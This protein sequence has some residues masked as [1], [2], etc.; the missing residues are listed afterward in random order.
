MAP[1]HSPNFSLRQIRYF[2]AVA[3][4][5]QV[6]RAAAVLHVTQSAVTVGLR[7]LESALGLPL[8]S[9][10][11]HGM[12]LTEHGRAFLDHALQIDA[13]VTRAGQLGT[14]SATR[15][16]LRLA[17]TNT[18]LG[19]FLP[20][21]LYRLHELH[22]QLKIDVEELPRAE[23]EAGLHAG[24]F[25]LGVMITSQVDDPGLHTQTLVQSARRLWL[26]SGHRW[27]GRSSVSLTELADEPLLMLTA[28]EAADSALRYWARH[29]LAPQVHIRS[30]SIEAIRSL[31]AYGEGVA[32]ASDM[33]YRPW[34]LEGRRV[35][36]LALMENIPPLAIGLA[37]T[38]RPE[39]VQAVASVLGYFGQRYIDPPQRH[40]PA[41][42]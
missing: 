19:Y 2:L 29:G 39:P 35:E 40:R 16:R 33:Q 36:T 10:E 14:A 4:L 28:D 41:L 42:R 20:E 15:G 1:A 7:D 12:E 22:P 25:E 3:Q 38:D 26:A 30:A 32:I 21:H 17:A 18:V 13:A 31:V 24:R 9:R 8:F 11:A 6:S 37:W 27:A 23:I 5:G 34:S